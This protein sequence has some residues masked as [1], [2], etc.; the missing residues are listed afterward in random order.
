MLHQTKLHHESQ[1][2]FAM[3]NLDKPSKRDT[4]SS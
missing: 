2:A 1:H 3:K 4:G